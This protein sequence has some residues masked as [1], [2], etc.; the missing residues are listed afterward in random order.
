MQSISPGLVATEFMAS[1]SMFSEEA[2]MVMPTLNPDDVATAA[3]YVL[4][5]P[6]HVLVCLCRIY[7]ERC[8]L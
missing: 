7:L 1:Y 5:N 4:S 6:P 3:I 2:M 8:F